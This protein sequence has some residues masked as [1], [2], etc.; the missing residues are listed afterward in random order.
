[1]SVQSASQSSQSSQP[2]ICLPNWFHAMSCWACA[3]LLKAPR[4]RPLTVPSPLPRR[5]D[6]DVNAP[7]PPPPVVVLQPDQGVCTAR[8]DAEWAAV[9]AAAAA[10]ERGEQAPKP[11][12]EGQQQQQAQQGGAGQP[13]RRWWRWL[14]PRRSRGAGGQPQ[15]A[16]G[17]EAGQSLEM[18]AAQQLQ[19]AA[20]QQAQRA[21]E[22]GPSSSSADSSSIASSLAVQGAP[23]AALPA[24]LPSRHGSI[25]QHLQQQ[26]SGH[27]S[28]RRSMQQP[29]AAAAGAASLPL[30]RAS[31]GQQAPQEQE[32]FR[33]APW[34]S[35]GSGSA[36]R[37]TQR[38]SM[39][40][41]VSRDQAL[42]FIATTQLSSAERR[43]IANERRQAAAARRPIPVYG[44]ELRPDADAD[45][46]ASVTASGF[47]T[48]LPGTHSLLVGGTA[49]GASGR[50]NNG[51]KL[52]VKTGKLSLWRL[53]P[54]FTFTFYLYL[55]LR[56]GST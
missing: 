4:P 30:H 22:A 32:V 12:D 3:A 33:A 2:A 39:G 34:L 52:D 6:V 23:D 44:V 55:G 46:D 36:S 7:P 9:A 51:L 38:A 26:P 1:M 18:A 29:A 25:E 15:H 17:L 5:A 43:M 31:T 13:P 54:T 53:F 40:Q 47:G 21:S 37:R 24:P 19:L 41:R 42:D 16:R 10:A 14:V 20:A 49:L 27:I 28:R 35:G 48:G 56:Q 50:S 8:M 11:A 45:L